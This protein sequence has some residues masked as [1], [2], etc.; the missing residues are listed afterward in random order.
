[1]LVKKSQIILLSILQRLKSINGM[2]N[3]DDKRIMMDKAVYSSQNIYLSIEK[4]LQKAFQ[5]HG[6]LQVS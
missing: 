4:R 5:N 3:G 1:M 6:N 2:F